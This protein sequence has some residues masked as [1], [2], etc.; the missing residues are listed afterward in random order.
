MKIIL[1][2]ICV[3]QAFGPQP[4]LSRYT[5]PVLVRKNIKYQPLSLQ[6]RAVLPNYSVE[7]SLSVHVCYRGTRSINEPPWRSH[8][9]TIGLTSK[10]RKRPRRIGTV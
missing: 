10:T 1:D 5:S 2:I 4:S 3:R 7:L 8:L 9:F 6:L